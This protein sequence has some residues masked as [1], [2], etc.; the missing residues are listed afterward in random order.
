MVHDSLGHTAGDLLL[1]AVSAR[2]KAGLRNGEFLA[3]VGGDEFTIIQ[4]GS[5]GQDRTAQ[6]AREILQALTE[7]YRIQ[8]QEISIGASV[9]ISRYPMDGADVDSLLQ[10]ADAAMYFAKQNRSQGFCFFDADLQGTGIEE[11]K[12][13]RNTFARHWQ[14]ESCM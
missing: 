14:R 6:L 11:E 10:G 4:P 5:D 1:R 3:R 7:P 8:S 13:W 12:R 2:L 9:G